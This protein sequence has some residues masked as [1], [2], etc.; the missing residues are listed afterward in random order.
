ML[1]WLDASLFC[2]DTG[3]IQGQS[4]FFS[5]LF[6]Y[7]FKKSKH[8]FKKK[9]AVEAAKSNRLSLRRIKIHLGRIHSKRCRSENLVFCIRYFLKTKCKS[10]KTITQRCLSCQNKSVPKISSILQ[11]IKIGPKCHICP[12]CTKPFNYCCHIKLYN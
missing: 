6:L 10:T 4:I 8:L 12:F 11:K 5:G 9:R 1:N 2:C 7:Y 3:S